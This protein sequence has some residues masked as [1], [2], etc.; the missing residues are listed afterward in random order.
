M[1]IRAIARHLGVD[2]NTVR[3]ALDPGR[4]E[5]YQRA[6][7]LDA[8]AHDAHTVLLAFPY[9]PAAGVARRLRF[10]GSLSHFTPWVNGIRQE[11]LADAYAAE[12][13]PPRTAADLG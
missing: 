11:V 8:L 6:S 3:R 7:Q 9:M 4:P 12:R 2:R 13:V 10:R 1:P 5:T